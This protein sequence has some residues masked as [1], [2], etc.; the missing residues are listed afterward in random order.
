[1][2]PSLPF[3]TMPL[4]ASL[5][6]AAAQPA[7]PLAEAAREGPPAC[8]YDDVPATI[9]PADD[10]RFT[11]L[12]TVFRLPADFVPTDLV[13]A[14]EA[15]L[16]DDRPVRQVIV[17]DLSALVRDAAA[18]G[19]P[20]ELQ[21]AYRSYDYQARTFDGWV[22]TDG[23]GAALATSAR[24]GHSEHQ[25]GTVVDL[26]SAGGPA[27][28]DLEDWAESPAGAWMAANAWRYGFVLSYP[29]GARDRACYAYEPWHWRWVGREL[30]ADVQ[31]RA[32]LPRDALWE[33]RDAE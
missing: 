33:L 14:R 25:L 9:V 5:A 32:A 24:A 1:M 18:A 23:R 17:A 26:R 16:D 30:A 27:P 13:P 7:A 19:H 31:Q 2:R 22:R 3:L 21:S 10:G 4:L 28:W 15:G 12:D 6:L 20:L 8:R 11:V 29:E